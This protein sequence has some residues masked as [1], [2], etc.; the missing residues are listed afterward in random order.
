MISFPELMRL[1]AQH[2]S[3]N[4]PVK[5]LNTYRG[6]PITHAADVISIHKG[7]VV[8]SVHPEQAACLSLE[9]QTYVQSELLPEVFKAYVVAV[10][11]ARNQ[12]VLNEFTSAGTALGKRMTVRVQPQKPLEV[13][14]HDGVHRVPGQLADIS[15]KG[16]GIF[17]VA[18]YTY[19]DLCFEK[20]TKI[21]IE[22]QLPITDTFIRLSGKINSLTHQRG[23]FLHRLGLSISPDPQAEAALTQYVTSRQQEI[24]E[25]LKRVAECMHQDASLKR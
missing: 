10:D 7:Y 13:A 21:Y 19:G 11:M 17:T 9:N 18:A 24:L 1:F 25:E 3:Q 8:F 6:V 14:L 22:F 2:M 4:Q 5:L 12:A 23:T 15:S 16:V 20:G